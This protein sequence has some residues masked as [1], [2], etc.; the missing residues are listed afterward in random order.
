MK[1]FRLRP[2]T[3]TLPSVPVEVEA[4]RRNKN[5]LD[6]AERLLVNMIADEVRGE[7]ILDLGVGAGRTAW[8]LRIL[9]ANYV[10]VDISPEMV[11]TCRE[12]YP[13]ID[14]RQCDARELSM[15]GS[16]SFGLVVFSFNGIDVLDHDGRLLAFSEIHRVLKPGGLFLY[17]TTTKGGPNY[18]RRPWNIS[19][20]GKHISLRG[21]KRPT[22]FLRFLMHL[23][24]LLPRYRRT[25]SNW[26]ERRR[27]EEDHISW[28]IGPLHAHE[29]GVLCHF[30]L[31]STEYQVLDEIGLS[32]IT[33]LDSDGHPVNDG[34]S[35]TKWFHVLARKRVNP[36]P[37]ASPRDETAGSDVTSSAALDSG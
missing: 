19:S 28:A 33:M 26:W 31:P 30:T 34:A 7:P 12:E 5:W 20:E 15:F 25:Y 29:F 3:A 9:S 1:T 18:D 24:Q 10:A 17:S 14:V 8:I 2:S 37:P 27:Y 11:K 13:G 16:C 22:R 35:A 21:H 4:Y 36:E 32:V 6:A 23:P